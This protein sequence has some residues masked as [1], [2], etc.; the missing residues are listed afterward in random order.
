MILYSSLQKSENPSSAS[1][2]WGKTV[3][4]PRAGIMWSQASFLERDAGTPLT[5]TY[6]ICPKHTLIFQASPHAA[7]LKSMFKQFSCRNVRLAYLVEEFSVLA[8]FLQVLIG[9]PI[10]KVVGGTWTDRPWWCH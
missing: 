3:W 5:S 6:V 1:T 4:G 8:G 2:V 10:V 9:I 7:D